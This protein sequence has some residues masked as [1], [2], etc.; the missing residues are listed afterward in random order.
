MLYQ[1]GV[2]ISVCEPYLR[3]PLDAIGIVFHIS[4][5]YYDRGHHQC[6]NEGYAVAVIERVC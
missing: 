5:Q 4:G 1:V 2:L 3:V 6:S